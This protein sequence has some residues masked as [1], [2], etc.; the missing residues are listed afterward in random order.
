MAAKKQGKRAATAAPTE[1]P[2]E[3]RPESLLA[4]LDRRRVLEDRLLIFRMAAERVRSCLLYPDEAAVIA[5]WLDEVG[6][7]VDP[8]K[9]LFGETR[10]RKRGANGVKVIRGEEVQIPDHVDLVWAMRAAINE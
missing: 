5:R 6:A 9:A 1:A 3:A 8:K 4:R 10:G 7:G 2:L